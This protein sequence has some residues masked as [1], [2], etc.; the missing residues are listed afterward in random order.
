MRNSPWQRV[1][2]SRRC[3][4]CGKHDWCL[5][6]GP[7]S[8][9]TAAICARIESDKRVG[10]AGWLHQLRDDGLRRPVVRSVTIEPNKPCRDF[11]DL[12][13]RCTRA[14]RPQSLAK[15]SDGLALS[16][17]SL[18]RLSIGWSYQQGAWTFP[19]SDAAGNVVGIRLRFPNGRKLAIKG[20]KDGLFIPTD[21][22]H[23]GKLLISE[24]PTDT[25]ALLELGFAAVGRPSCTGGIKHLIELICRQD[26]E[27]VVV[28]ADGDGPGRCGAESLV[29]VLRAYSGK[30]RTIEPPDG[31]KDARAWKQAG[32]TKGDVERIIE[33][34]IVKKLEFETRKVG[35]R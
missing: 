26:V 22:Q 6:A 11:G 32:A 24:G 27:D 3:T 17:S 7:D 30:V 14:T 4:I 1:S 28:V 12:A 23:Q 2:K 20:G 15:L 33:A 34:A 25:A 29:S 13:R 19:M 18:Q 8:D 35:G 16:M 31:I 9:P 21:L 10:E 5:F